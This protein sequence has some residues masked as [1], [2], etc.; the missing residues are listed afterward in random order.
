[1]YVHAL[2]TL[3]FA[4]VSHVR[5]R[6]RL[7][8]EK[9]LSKDNSDRTTRDRDLTLDTSLSRK[10]RADNGRPGALSPYLLLPD[11]ERRA[12]LRRRLEPFRADLLKKMRP[13]KGVVGLLTLW[14]I[15]VFFVVRWK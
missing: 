15:Y 5:D 1:V 2:N 7:G 13:H 4:P 12:W 8:K 9:G 11:S 3:D 14:E 10:H 6:G